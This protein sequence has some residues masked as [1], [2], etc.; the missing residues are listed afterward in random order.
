MTTHTPSWVKD[1]VFYQIFPDRFFRSGRVRVDAEIEPWD[2]PP[3][4]HGFKGGDLYGV[5]EKL[6]Y[7]GEL[8][9]TAIYCCPIFASTANH[10]YHTYDYYQVD[11]LLGGNEALRCLLDAAHERDMKV[12][13]DGVFNHTGRGFWP[14]HHVLE[15]GAASPYRDWFHIDPDRLSGKKP[16]DPYPS[17]ET[18]QRLAGGS[19]SLESIGYSAWWNLPALPKLNTACPAVRQYLLEVAEHWVEFGIDGWRL[20]VPDE[21]DDDGFWR[22]FRCRVRNLN[23][24]T[25]I[26]GEI[27]GDAHRWL[28]GDMWDA[29]TNYPLTIACL[30]FFP[31]DYIDLPEIRRVSSYSQIRRWTGSE[32]ADRVVGVAGR[33]APEVTR[34]QLNF[35][36]S[37]D[38]PRFLTCS[39]GDRDSLKMAWLFLCTVSGA[40]CIYYGDEVGLEGRHDPDCRRGFPWSPSARDDDMQSWFTQCIRTRKRFPQLRKARLRVIESSADAVSFMHGE[41]PKSLISAYNIG[42]APVEFRFDPSLSAA[43]SLLISS[44][45]AT[46]LRTV[47]REYRLD[48]PARAAALIG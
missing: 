39:G 32:F 26:V 10:R 35:L 29:V 14:F 25:Y 47:G 8:G 18:A 15:N 42:K 40:P 28:T 46:R 38:T 45:P 36:D 24:E 22:E 37:H 21:I 23:P 4:A 11:P 13:L 6:D 1:A 41:A 34:S 5:V 44:S 33:Y 7:L 17:G 3:T 30:G 27:W 43:G 12:V 19:G 31:G 16:F 20:D 2:S 48:L 9:I